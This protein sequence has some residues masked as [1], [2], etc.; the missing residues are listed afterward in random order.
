MLG[1]PTKAAY[2]EIMPREV[3][4][5]RGFRNKKKDIGNQGLELPRI[6]E[7]FGTVLSS[8]CASICLDAREECAP[9][10]RL[11]FLTCYGILSST[12]RGLEYWSLEA[13]IPG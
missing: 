4:V 9:E 10:H 7:M 6:V 12:C 11:G 3:P 1:F 2:Q 5:V 8:R 13:H